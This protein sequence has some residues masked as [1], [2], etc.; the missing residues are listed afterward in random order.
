MANYGMVLGIFQEQKLVPPQIIRQFQQTMYNSHY[1]YF[2]ELWNTF[3][4]LPCASDYTKLK[5]KNEMHKNVFNKFRSIQEYDSLMKDKI[6]LRKSARIKAFFSWK[7]WDSQENIEVTKY[8]LF[9]YLLNSFLIFFVFQML[10]AATQHVK[11]LWKYQK[12]DQR[13]QIDLKVRR[14]DRQSN[15]SEYI[16]WQQKVGFYGEG[17]LHRTVVWQR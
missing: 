4:F 12:H 15:N 6:I 14:F 11:K 1:V 3:S 8:S 2:Y 9:M 10:S 7:S 13:A 17:P 5:N 16:G